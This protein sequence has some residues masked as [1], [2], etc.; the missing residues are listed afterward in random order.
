MLQTGRSRVPFPIRSLNF[1]IYLI[2]AVALWPWVGLSL[3]QKCGKGI[4]LG[5]K[6]A[7]A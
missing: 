5:V 6:G 2:L 4:F 1:L 3:K 7:G